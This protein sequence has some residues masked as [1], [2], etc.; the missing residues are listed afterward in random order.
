MDNQIIEIKNLTI[1]YS[2]K[3]KEEIIAKNIN[4]S[5]KKGTFI[6]LLGK[7]GAGKSTLLRTI[8]KVQPKLD[9]N[10]IL[11][12]KNIDSYTALD[13]SKKISLVLTEKLPENNLT[14]F[15]L[16]ALGRQPYTN[17]IG[18]LTKNDTAKIN[19]AMELTKI[20]H[21]S[22]K[23]YFE[24]SD[25]QLQK[26]LISRA[27]AQDTDLIILDEPTVHLDIQHK[28]ETFQLLKNLVNKLQKTIIISTHE[29]N[30]ALQTANELW[31]MTNNKII[32]G[33]TQNLIDNKS[34]DLLFTSN[35][36]YFDKDKQQFLLK[37]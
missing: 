34:V 15:E 14:V 8:T 21:L 26:V 16:I 23:K 9:G 13:L 30:L 33:N 18:T 7:N 4:I 24:L 32:T 29:I 22:K 19:Q 12:K 37:Q 17:W 5:I 3:K 36:I 6:C 11:N 31:L 20:K 10:I 35:T 27:L 1:G 28:M 2:S 25:G